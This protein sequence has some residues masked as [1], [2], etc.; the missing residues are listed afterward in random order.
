[1]KV[2]TAI[3]ALYP[4]RSRRTGT[5]VVAWLKPPSARGRRKNGPYRRGYGRFPCDI[6][7]A[8]RGI[9]FPGNRRATPIAGRGAPDGFGGR[10]NRRCHRRIVR[11]GFT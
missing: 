7:V 2:K 5:Q 10:M 4:S 3:A 8:G 1:M 6:T 9:A 11:H